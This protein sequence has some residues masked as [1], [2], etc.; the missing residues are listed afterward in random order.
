[1]GLGCG[2]RE[3]PAG[4]GYMGLGSCGDCLVSDPS[5]G[6]CSVVDTA[7][8]S[9]PTGAP[10][11]TDPYNGIL[12]PSSSTG[13]SSSSGSSPSAAEIQAMANLATMWTKIAG[14][15]ISPQTTIQTP[16]GLQISTPAG[17]TSA[18]SALFGTSLTGSTAS[19]LSSY[20]PL[21]LLAGAGF[22]LFKAISK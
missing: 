5:T 11:A 10:N 2:C 20:L 17:Q 14:Q 12:P 9:N 1:M 4:M 15:T 3:Q 7:S 13:S 8:C 6:D 16:S 18:L 19:S 21:L 22:L